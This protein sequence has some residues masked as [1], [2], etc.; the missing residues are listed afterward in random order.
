MAVGAVI[1]LSPWIGGFAAVTAAAWTMWLVGVA[2]I[3]LGAYGRSQ[4]KKL[5]R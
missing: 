5:V 2:M 4:G 1:F 3:A